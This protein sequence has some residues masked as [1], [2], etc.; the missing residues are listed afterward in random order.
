ML[1]TVT[2]LRALILDV[3][4]DILLQY[5]KSASLRA[6]NHSVSATIDLMVH[7]GFI[8]VNLLTALINAFEFKIVKIP[9]NKSV[10]WSEFYCFVTFTFLRA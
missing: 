3:K 4:L 10:D 2:G 6:L 1:A 5:S 8:S 9:L 7:G